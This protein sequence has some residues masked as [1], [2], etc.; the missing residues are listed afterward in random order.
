MKNIIL[1]SSLVF[2]SFCGTKKD[3]EKTAAQPVIN[4]NLVTL[5]PAQLTSAK[6]GLGVLEEKNISSIIKVTGKIDV[7]PQNM[8][9]VSMPLG[10][11]LRSTHLLPGMHVKKGEVIAI[12]E[13]QQYIQLQQD[14][15]TTKAKLAY[16][17]VEL[18]R[19]KELNQSKASSDKV[20][21]QAQ[22]EFANQKITLGALAE[23]LKL[24]NINPA[25]LSESSISK[26]VNIYSPI[27][28]FVSKVNVNIG[29]F[30]NPIDVLFE[31]VNPSDIHLNLKIFEKDLEK[32]S[33]GQKL[34]AYTN[35]DPSRKYIC[36]ISLISQDLSPERIADVHCHFEQYDKTLVPGM[37]MNGE[38]KIKSQKTLALPDDAIVNYEG[39]NYLFIGKD[40]NSF[41][42]TEVITG[43]KENGF[44]EIKNPQAFANRQVVVKGAYTLLMALK[45]KAEE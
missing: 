36:E 32:L 33:I 22:M 26:S 15:L 27:N 25:N 35:N 30:V 9:S 38:I 2:F 3:P 7:P 41:L 12:M 8:F 13:D 43:V 39:T 6:L 16:A 44:T 17:E 40:Q 23:K 19:Q 37:Y 14:Y 28:G 24:I 42:M 20:Y 11:Y 4:E 5:T 1:I 34:V 31:L 18:Q 10:G 45:N 29:K 21:Q